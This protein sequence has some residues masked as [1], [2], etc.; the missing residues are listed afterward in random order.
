[1]AALLYAH[2]R[3]VGPHGINITIMMKGLAISSGPCLYE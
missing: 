2:D 1:M 3:G